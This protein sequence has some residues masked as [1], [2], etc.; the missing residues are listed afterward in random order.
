MKKTRARLTWKKI[1]LFIRQLITFLFY[2]IKNIFRKI[3]ITIVKIVHKTL[4][5]CKNR[6][7]IFALTVFIVI[8]FITI[9]FIRYHLPN[10]IYTRSDNSINVNQNVSYTLSI[11]R[12][13]NTDANDIFKY[14]FKEHKDFIPVA[15]AIYYSC[16][17][18]KV[19][20][21]ETLAIAIL[22]SGWGQGE[23]ARNKRNYFS[24]SAYDND[25]YNCASDWSKVPLDDAIYE[26]VKIIKQD[27]Y[28]K[29]GYDL[30]KI[31]KHYAPTNP[32]WAELVKE[33]INN[34]LKDLYVKQLD[35]DIYK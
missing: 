10:N 15:K 8:L 35:N 18:L 20:F 12:N 26:Q 30:K 9:S 1:I 32:Q 19:P 17:R 7:L 23:I 31:G 14:F 2:I 4:N 21:K 33:I 34:D 11:E 3:Y 6:Y 25:P 5:G 24:I 13:Q 28:D 22:E 16:D 29:Y 27:F